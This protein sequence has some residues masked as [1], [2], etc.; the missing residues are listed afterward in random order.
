[1]SYN[2]QGLNSKLKQRTLAN[3][4]TKKKIIAMLIQETKIAKESQIQIRD[5]NGNK[6]TLNN[7]GKWWT[8][9]KR[10]RRHDE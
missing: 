2:V 9:N 8:I 3:E 10:S 1:M 7:S 4:F 6:L 5:K